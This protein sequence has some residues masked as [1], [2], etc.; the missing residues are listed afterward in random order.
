MGL[1]VT[2]GCFNGPY[3]TFH[4]WRCEI[5]K[6]AGIPIEKM[7]GCCE[8]DGVIPIRWRSLEPDILHVLLFH[9][10]YD[11]SIAFEQCGPL[12]DRLQQLLDIMMANSDTETDEQIVTRK[13][14][15]G[16]RRAASR[17]KGVEFE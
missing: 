6:V 10:D 12:A 8:E 15:K 14:I 4:W 3:R 2:H 5:A 7:E 11:G 1:T 13:F 16:L 9:S 17:K